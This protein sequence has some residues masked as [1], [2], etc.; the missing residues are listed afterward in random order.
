MRGQSLVSLSGTLIGDPE[1]RFT[2]NGTAVAR[3]RMESTPTT[4]DGQS[5]SWVERKPLRYVCTVWRELA[6]HV[7]ESLVDG[8]GVTVHG[9]LTAIENDVTHI[10]VDDVGVSLRQRIVY[11]EASLP[12]PHATGPQS[13]AP[14]QAETPARP[15][16]PRPEHPPAAA[17]RE[18][19][20]TPSRERPFSVTT[21]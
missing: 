19:W 3:F 2:P 16:P 18:W 13:T 9:R 12:G 4:W 5:G 17:P 8:V 1:I 10:S 6:E 7:A 21:G 14:T 20:R 15:I 11:T